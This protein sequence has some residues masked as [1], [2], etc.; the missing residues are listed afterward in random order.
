[1]PNLNDL[2]RHD[3]LGTRRSHS[4]GSKRNKDTVSAITAVLLSYFMELLHLKHVSHQSKAKGFQRGGVS[5]PFGHF[6][7]AVLKI[8]VRK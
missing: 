3:R 2:Q 4:W 5:E 7:H 8:Q 6:Q 1:M